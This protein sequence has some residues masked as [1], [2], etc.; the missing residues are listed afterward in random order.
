MPL[1]IIAGGLGAIGALLLG[2]AGNGLQLFVQL[3]IW[4][5]YLVGVA[6]LV[7]LNWNIGVSNTLSF[8]VGGLLFTP[9]QYAFSSLGF[10]VITFEGLSA[11]LVVTL[12]VLFVL[13][14]KKR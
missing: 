9:F 6:L 13:T 1:P 7:A 2:I 12:L 14:L 11:V 5:K 8:S 3:P 4:M 10:G